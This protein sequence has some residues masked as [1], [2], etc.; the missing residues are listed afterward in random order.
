MYSQQLG[1]GR[2]SGGCG[3][4]QLLQANDNRSG[5]EKLTGSLPDQYGHSVSGAPNT[6]RQNAATVAVF[7]AHGTADKNLVRTG[8]S[9]CW[10]REEC[11][12][13]EDPL[14]SMDPGG[15]LK[16]RDDIST[17]NWLIARH[18]LSSNPNT[19]LFLPDSN[20]RDEKKIIQRNYYAEQEGRITRYQ[21]A[22]ISWLERIGAK[23]NVP[24][25]E[26]GGDYDQSV[27]TERFFEIHADMLH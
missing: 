21:G 10:E 2:R 14:F 25:V 24:S 1:S 6:S 26:S 23:H 22:P 20:L 5:Y 15:A 7:Y 19:S 16:S 11:D 8:D 18:Q 12:I 13:S 27:Y 17:I 9:G 3:D 4:G